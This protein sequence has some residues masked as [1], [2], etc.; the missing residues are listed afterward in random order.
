FDSQN[1]APELTEHLP[2]ITTVPDAPTEDITRDVLPEGPQFAI[3]DRTQHLPTPSTVPEAAS[4][5]NI[6]DFLSK[7]PPHPTDAEA[8]SGAPEEPSTDDWGFMSSKKDK[9]KGKKPK[10]K[11]SGT[12]TPV[13][14]FIPKF[15]E[16]SVSEPVIP[17]AVEEAPLI[18]T[19]SAEHEQPTEDEW[20]S[21]SSKKDKK[22]SKKS[23]GK[24][25]GAILEFDPEVEP[26][27]VALES[28]PI[29]ADEIIPTADEGLPTP[30]PQAEAEQPS[31]EDWGS[32]V[33]KQDKKKGK[34]GKTSV[35]DS[36]APELE[37]PFQGASATVSE[38][39][40]AQPVEPV[41]IIE[42]VLER[43]E[44]TVEPQQVRDTDT[45]LEKPALSRKS[46]KKEKKAK[47]RSTALSWNEE[48]F[49]DPLISAQP[50]E[51]DILPVSELTEQPSL[52]EHIPI[53]LP[54]PFA[55]PVEASEEIFKADRV[56]PLLEQA[57]QQ[58]FDKQPPLPQEK[59]QERFAEDDWSATT[60]KNTKKSKDKKSK[61]QSESLDSDEV[62]QPQPS[63]T[64]TKES[65][66]A[67]QHTSEPPRVV[68]SKNE[69]PAGIAPLPQPLDKSLDLVE[70]SAPE[71][72][73][74]QV[75]EEVHESTLPEQAVNLAHDETVKQS[76][77]REL[78]VEEPSTQAEIVET[79]KEPEADDAWAAIGRKA[80]KKSKKSKDE[81]SQ[82]VDLSEEP[83]ASTTLEPGVL[84]EPS[85]TLLPIETEAISEPVTTEEA[86]KDQPEDLWAS[87]SKKSKKDKKKGKKSKSTS[88]AA[89]PVLEKESA[90]LEEPLGRDLD[91]VPDAQT[92]EQPPVE[93]TESLEGILVTKGKQT[94]INETTV[95]P[96]KEPAFS[97]PE[98]A[99]A[100]TPFIV[101]Q[102]E[103]MQRSTPVEDLDELSIAP[104]SK[105]KSKK[106]KK[107][108]KAS[109]RTGLN[110]DGPSS[111]L[112]S[113]ESE[114]TS[115]FRE[116][117]KD[118]QSLSPSQSVA[119]EE[120]ADLATQD[121]PKPST[122]PPRS[123]A[124]EAPQLPL[125]IE[126]Q[127]VSVSIPTQTPSQVLE[128]DQRSADAQALQDD[129][130]DFKQRSEALEKAL[131][132]AEESQTRLLEEPQ[133]SR[134]SSFFDKGTKSKGSALDLSEPT[135]PT[136][137][138][139]LSPQLSTQEQKTAPIEAPSSTVSKKDKKKRGKAA[140]FSWDEPLEE[141]TTLL[142]GQDS[143]VDEPQNL[144]T[145][146]VLAQSLDAPQDRDLGDF[147]TP[148]RKLSKKDK[149]KK[150]KS[151]TFDSEK[152][153]APESESTSLHDTGEPIEKEDEL[154]LS[155]AQTTIPE[156][157]LTLEREPTL[158]SETREERSPPPIPKS[159]IE[160]PEPAVEDKS[161]A[162][163]TWDEPTVDALEKQVDPRPPTT[164]QEP[165]LEEPKAKQVTLSWDEPGPFTA[166]AYD[167][168][169]HRGIIPGDSSVQAP[170]LEAE[171]TA[172]SQPQEIPEEEAIGFSTPT[173][174]L[175]KKDKKKKGKASAMIWDEPAEQ[176]SEPLLA[177]EALEHIEGRQMSLSLAS[178]PLAGRPIERAQI[179]ISGVQ[180]TE[181]VL[182]QT[183]AETQPSGREIELPS[184]QQIDT[185]ETVQ[186]EESLVPVSHNVEPQTPAGYQQESLPTSAQDH[187]HQ[188][189][190]QTTEELISLPE[191]QTAL[192]QEA[193]KKS[194][195]A[196]LAWDEPTPTLEESTPVLETQDVLEPEAPIDD[197][198]K[199]T[200]VVLD[201]N[202]PTPTLEELPPNEKDKKKGKKKNST[203]DYAAT[204]EPEKTQDPAQNVPLFSE[205][206]SDPQGDEEMVEDSADRSITQMDVPPSESIAPRI[207][208]EISAD[209]MLNQPVPEPEFRKSKK[210]FDNFE[211]PSIISEFQPNIMAM[212]TELEA[213]TPAA[214][215]EEF[216]FP[217]KKNKKEKHKSKQ[218]SITFDEL[219][220]EISSSIIQE[221]VPQ[222]VQ[223]V[224]PP[225]PA[226]SAK[227]PKMSSPPEA[228]RKGKIG[229]L[230][231]MFEQSIP[232]R[233][234]SS[235][236]D[237]KE[238]EAPVKPLPQIGPDQMEIDDQNK[239]S[240]LQGPIANRDMADKEHSIGPDE[241]LQTIAEPRLK[242]SGFDDSL[243]L[244][245]P[246]FRRSTSPK[247]TRDISPEDDFSEFGQSLTE[248]AMASTQIFSQ[249][250]TSPGV[251]E[252][253]DPEELYP[254]SK[255][256]KKAKGKKKKTSIP[257][258]PADLDERA[259]DQTETKPMEIEEADRFYDESL[260]NAMSREQPIQFE[261][262]H[263]APFEQIESLN[264]TPIEEEP[265]PSWASSKTKGKKAKKDK[266]RTSLA[267][268]II[269]TST[270]EAP[271][272]EAPTVVPFAVETPVDVSKTSPLE[273]EMRKSPQQ[274]VLTDTLA[275]K[276]TLDMG[277]EMDKDQL[278]PA[279][280][281]KEAE[282][283]WGEQSNKKS[284]KGKG[285]LKRPT[286]PLLE[287]E[288]L[289]ETE[290]W[291]T[292]GSTAL[293]VAGAAALQEK[294]GSRRV[295]VG[296]ELEPVKTTDPKSLRGQPAEYPFP[297]VRQPEEIKA[298]DT[299]Q[300]KT[301][302][303]VKA[304]KGKKDKRKSGTVEQEEIMQEI[305]HEKEELARDDAT[306]QSR[307][308]APESG[309]AP[310][311]EPIADIHDAHVTPFDTGARDLE[312]EL[313][314]RTSPS[315]KRRVST[316]ETQPEEKQKPHTHHESAPFLRTFPDIDTS[317]PIS[318]GSIAEASAPPPL[319]RGHSP[320]IEPTCGYYDPGSAT[321]DD[322]RTV[323]RIS[324]HVSAERAISQ[325]QELSSFMERTSHLFDSSPSTRSYVESPL[326]VTKGRKHDIAAAVEPSASP[327]PALK[328]HMDRSS[329][330]RQTPHKEPI[331]SMFGDP[332]ERQSEKTATYSTP[333]HVKT[334]NPQ[335][336]TIKESRRPISDRLKSPPPVTPT[337][338]SPW[339]QVHGDQR[340]GEERSPSVLSDRSAGNITRFRTP[341]HLRT[342]SPASDRAQSAGATA[343]IAGLASSS[344]Y[345]PI[346][347]QGKGRADMPDVY[348]S[349]YAV[350]RV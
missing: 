266:K 23:K 304:K 182:P 259:T 171:L 131:E 280:R 197:F 314:T 44:E 290:D 289:A 282:D 95:Q 86:K 80:S 173:R 190:V 138:A 285:K 292:A 72:H 144:E 275:K 350:R 142:E 339:Q 164:P 136:A 205:T 68:E 281:T 253:A 271:A 294:Q 231:A 196:A 18:S 193:I 161:K 58:V 38:E 90:V 36:P 81:S 279:K 167:A 236:K 220:Q 52:S 284:K 254:T 258:T 155:E 61:K 213:P 343:A 260:I 307:D 189:E 123:P 249:R 240:V 252:E 96:V 12:A 300:V 226:T 59:V 65:L 108:K 51:S 170:I 122:S 154:V 301:S 195:S 227:E 297:D 92:I 194:K 303:D 263:T 181:P 191:T 308:Q 34:K 9:K 345:D 225:E 125:A 305:K 241:T 214:E 88:G 140:A 312:N 315:A 228:K 50:E 177:P 1:V 238:I 250:K 31:E 270:V 269:E 215:N 298:S 5:D 165:I 272:I 145:P 47:K 7:E 338:D 121:E 74:P 27:R 33:S 120:H 192:E 20:R 43:S 153:L 283:I 143:I 28:A 324:R 66:P 221:I 326:V 322:D 141:R 273:P 217:A 185:Q 146:E 319:S 128:K 99:L 176:P 55:N 330:T 202:E 212:S 198:K 230:A 67:T 82:S 201:W 219:K 235:K 311:Y 157:P 179:E 152:P 163:V 184:Q 329:P 162:A 340:M 21:S 13:P 48:T 49:S 151:T 203:F 175:S 73:Q 299:E 200:A 208:D 344:K 16:E 56:T 295:H 132:T 112:P 109:K 130:A 17:T 134:S 302:R 57:P 84:L 288:Q 178:L 296:E 320:I 348:V 234:A 101:N 245:D 332:R 323:E 264:A 268:D 267:Q 277:D 94:T 287:S 218:T 180:Q 2:T 265:E 71:H 106:D 118:K 188:E 346:R 114:Q 6:Q 14:D 199:G 246:T 11:A 261:P 160:S 209:T 22:K 8:S 239:E 247:G 172:R 293:L 19:P 148:T 111:S 127:D 317:Q 24:Q 156:E 347:G 244:N 251:L 159:T 119:I 32:R 237:G 229:K 243:V 224:S 331:P 117:L 10:G 113:R 126:S 262:K 274:E 334:P 291:E 53:D 102:V 336:D 147:S 77:T 87:S 70:E 104:S 100:D 223:E 248:V 133:A 39:P 306:V 3:E 93:E 62:T 207:G 54:T 46:S 183:Y 15:Q 42:P 222:F 26:E 115:I 29:V 105:K 85:V 204:E 310:I 276:A 206:T 150:A 233:Q 342:M 37:E 242:E 187:V 349:S 79:P 69:A 30:T 25:S 174:K 316:P 210:A 309:Q 216:P 341:D 139:V 137:E 76:P 286:T 89:T 335:L 103:E 337:P 327:K 257:T 158:L 116:D 211:E 325:H 169:L 64:S 45:S 98:T 83:S 278:Q 110:I 186:S 318:D 232:E 149:K 135:T 91:L 41:D 4:T 97:L 313:A 168:P 63:L 35:P 166:Q 60:P 107:G 129:V 333:R 75:I 321:T 78:L 40:V 328:Q 256:T 124:Q 255:K